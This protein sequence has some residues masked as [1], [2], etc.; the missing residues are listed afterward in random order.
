VVVK[1]PVFGLLV[2]RQLPLP[3]RAERD[4][5]ATAAKAADETD[6]GFVVFGNRRIEGLRDVLR[7]VA[8]ASGLAADEPDSDTAAVAGDIEP[9]GDDG[10]EIQVSRVEKDVEVRMIKASVRVPG[11]LE[12]GTSAAY[13]V[14]PPWTLAKSLEASVQAIYLDFKVRLDAAD[15]QRE[16][17]V[18]ATGEVGVEAAADYAATCSR[19]R[20]A[21]S[22]V[23]GIG[24][25]S[26]RVGLP[27][28]AEHPPS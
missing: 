5:E 8:D 10:A 3:P 14:F 6:G 24:D 1:L 15:G 20:L 13:A 17:A 11:A 2:T 23:T 18:V 27:F 4:D 7:H 25:G 12:E 21:P 26:E 28:L 16:V 9:V 19:T 22:G